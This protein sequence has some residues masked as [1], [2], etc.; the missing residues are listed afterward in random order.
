MKKE[1]TKNKGEN[2]LYSHYFGEYEGARYCKGNIN[3]KT[4][5]GIFELEGGEIGDFSFSLKIGE[6]RIEINNI[7]EVEEFISNKLHINCE[8]INEYSIGIIDEEVMNNADYTDYLQDLGDKLINKLRRYC[9][10]IDGDYNIN[11]DGYALTLD[12]WFD[13]KE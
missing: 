10:V 1:Q 8:I 7:E 3:D 4:L 13:E 2:E 5:M 9:N 12:L 6:K 11:S